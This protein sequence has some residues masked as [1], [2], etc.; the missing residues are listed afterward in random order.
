MFHRTRGEKEV[1]NKMKKIMLATILAIGLIAAPAFA[2]PNWSKNPE[3]F[4]HGIVI[5]LD[6]EDYYFLGPP[7]GSGGARDIPGHSW[8]YGDDPYTLVGRHYNIGPFGMPQW[9]SSDASNGQLLFMVHAIIAPWTI[10]IVE[11]MSKR[12]YIH[13][14][15]L[16]HVTTGM[17][18]P[19]MVVW[20]RHTAVSSF[21]FD[22]G[23]HPEFGHH[24]TPGV[25][26]E[27]IPNWMMPYTPLEAADSLTDS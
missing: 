25:D 26:Y 18:H 13:Y 11:R 10:E 24:V 16:V 1:K 27:F 22:G 21:T 6:Q 8:V 5:T 17:K 12:G 15:E 14:H 3:D 23:P 7:D 20:L 9:W 19:T 4:V 2:K